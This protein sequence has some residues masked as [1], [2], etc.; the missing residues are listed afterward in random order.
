MDIKAK[1]K[2]QRPT[3]QDIADKVGVTKMTVSRFLRDPNT[4]AKSTQEKIRLCINE[5]GYIHNR[6]PAMLSKAS[7]KTIGV[8]LPSLSN[9]VFAQFT[10][11]VESITDEYG[12][13]TLI[14]HYSYDKNE[15]ERKIEVMLSY[16]VDGLILTSSSH[17][18]RTLKM[19]NTVKIPVVEAMEIPKKPIDM[20]VGLNH[21]LAAYTIVRKMID[22]GY[23]NIAYLGAR[24]DT[25]TQLRMQGYDR[26]LIEANLSPLHV[27]TEE[28]SSYTLGKQLFN[29]AITKN[30]QLEGVF[31]TNDD[32]AVGAI[33][34]CHDAHI[35]IPS[36]MAIVGYNALDIGYA[37][38]PTLTSIKVP[39]F[40][41]GKISADMILKSIQG[42]PLSSKSID[43]GFEIKQGESFLPS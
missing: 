1:P 31:C 27:L 26:A 23:R 6:T 13:D 7:S 12:F 30:P 39:L 3:L 29:E 9:Q 19:L 21:E 5:L 32:I 35:S 22:K 34:A 20:S 40:E 2:L 36:E 42:H 43:F 14:A 10:Q 41:I 38:S 25:R 28:H 11:G 15:E 24:L 17:T 16:Q 18:K 8:L 4:V 37:I 33:L